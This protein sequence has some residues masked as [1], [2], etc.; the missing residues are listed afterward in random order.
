MASVK[1]IRDK[2]SG[3]YFSEDG[4]WRVEKCS[5]GWNL[6]DSNPY[7]GSHYTFPAGWGSK[8]SNIRSIIDEFSIT[9]IYF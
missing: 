4:R 5:D 7:T 8:L 1:L 3:C 9:D 6:Y 2:K